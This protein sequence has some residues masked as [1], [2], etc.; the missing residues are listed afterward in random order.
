MFVVILC[1]A[2]MSKLMT[3]TAAL[4]NNFFNFEAKIYK[5]NDGEAMGSPQGLTLTNAF[6]CF[7]EQIWVGE[8]PDKFKPVNNKILC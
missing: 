8:C 6:L 1:L 2:I 5:R 4:Q 3:L 7:H